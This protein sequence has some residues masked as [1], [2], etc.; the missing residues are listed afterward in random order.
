MHRLITATFDLGVISIFNYML[1]YEFQNNSVFLIRQGNNYHVSFL[2]HDVSL[3]E[4]VRKTDGYSGA[5]ICALCKEAA[6]FALRDSISAETIR[7]AHFERSFTIVKPRLDSKS[8][9][10][11][12]QFSSKFS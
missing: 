1:I 6:I 11:Y 7:L 3:Q 4:L 10:Y 8:I 9:D 2:D 5:E 12:S